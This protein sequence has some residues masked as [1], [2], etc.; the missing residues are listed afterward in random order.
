MKMSLIFPQVVASCIVLSCPF[1][2]TVKMADGRH[3]FLA[4]QAWKAQLH[5]FKTSTSY[6]IL[7]FSPPPSSGFISKLACSFLHP[8]C[9]LPPPSGPLWFG[10]DWRW[11]RWRLIRKEQNHFYLTPFLPVS[12][13]WACAAVYETELH[14]WLS[15]SASVWLHWKA[16]CSL[17]R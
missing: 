12:Y 11:G 14:R 13:W 2:A 10:W 1:Q 5:L 4:V 6:P 7:S 8:W 9:L 16:S 17:T 3:H 15:Q